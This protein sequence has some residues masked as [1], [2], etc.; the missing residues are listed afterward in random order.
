MQNRLVGDNMRELMHTF[1][2]AKTLT[3][4]V[5]SLDAETAFVHID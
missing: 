3:T 4:P 1:Y 5:V 2:N